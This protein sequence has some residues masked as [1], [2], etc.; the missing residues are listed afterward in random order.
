MAFGTYGYPLSVLYC[1]AQYVM[2]KQDRH[3][4]C[5]VALAQPFTCNVALA[6]PFTCNVALAQPL[7]LWKNN[8]CYVFWVCVC[9]FL[10]HSCTVLYCHLWPAWLLS[11]FPTLS[12]KQHNCQE[13]VVEHKMCVLIFYTVYL[14]HLL[15]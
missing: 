4:T 11:Y 12:N 9:V 13:N 6:Q 2:K 5:N 14:K 3:F 15:F 8:K 10:H 7:W 1:M